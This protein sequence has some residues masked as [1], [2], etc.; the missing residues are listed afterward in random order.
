MQ[1]I[2]LLPLC[3]LAGCQEKSIPMGGSSSVHPLMDV[4]KEDFRAEY[5]NEYISYDGPGS[6]KGVEGIKNGIYQFGFLSRELKDNEKTPDMS[7]ETICLDGIALVVNN[8]NP[9]TNLTSQQIKDIYEG[10]ITNWQEVGGVDQQIS[11]IARDNA[12]GTRAAFDQVLGINQLSNNALLY[13]SN[14]AVVQAIENN[15]NAIGY[16]SFDTL[17]RNENIIK[18]L[19]INS[20]APTIFNVENKN[21]MLYRPFVMV[22]YQD[23][24]TENSKVFLNWFNENKKRLVMEAGFIPIGG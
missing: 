4:V 2:L 23:K 1:I 24:L 6:S 7:I 17:I 20:Y 12:S 22:Y 9:I 19:S 13:D 14:G 11:I 10:V 8:N 18:P 3:F 21:Y 15:V 5:P 16:I